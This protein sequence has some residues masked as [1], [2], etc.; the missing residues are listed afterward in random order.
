MLALV[1]E[2]GEL[3]EIMQWSSD[4]DLLTEIESES[5]EFGRELAD[6]AI[7]L[8]LLSSQVGVNLGDAIEEKIDENEVRYG[9]GAFR[10][11]SRKAPHD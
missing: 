10:G 3:A 1:G 5:T 9:K 4:E 8:I 2:V 6:V 7:Y 11:S